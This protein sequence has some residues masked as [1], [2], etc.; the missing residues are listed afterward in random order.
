MDVDMGKTPAGGYKSNRRSRM[1]ILLNTLILMAVMASYTSYLIYG[2]AVANVREAGE[3][4]I[5]GAAAQI[6]NY[7]STAQSLHWV[8]ADAV[9]YMTRTGRTN[10]D[11]LRYITEESEKHA[12]Q[13]DENY[14]G[15]YGYIG[16]EYLNGMDWTPPAG[17][18]P[19]M[20]P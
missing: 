19:L 9:D 5:S 8:T 11:I 3:D 14:S 2:V 13:F 20:R 6:E 1:S 12:H 16:G 7:L 4:R 17:Y 18:D 10:E 15:L